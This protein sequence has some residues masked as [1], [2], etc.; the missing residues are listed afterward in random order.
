MNLNGHRSD[1]FRAGSSAPPEPD[2]SPQLSPGVLAG[3]Q[4][5]VERKWDS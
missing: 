2:G 4:A 5:A 1:I 3:L